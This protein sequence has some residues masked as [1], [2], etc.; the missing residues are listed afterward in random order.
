MAE[1]K[2][3]E[4]ST[5]IKKKKWY[6]I[7][8][9]KIFRNVVLGETYLTE[10]NLALN[11]TITQNLMNLTYDVKRQNSNIKFLIDKVEGDKAYTKIIG[12]HMI[13][14]SVRRLTRR[15]SEKIEQSLVCS[16]SDNKRVR[17]KPLIF[18]RRLIKGSISAK[19]AKTIIEYL[20]KTISKVTYD[21]LI[22]DLITHKLQNS[23]RERLKSIYPL[24]AVEIKSMEIEKEKKPMEE[25][26]TEKAEEMSETQ[27]VSEHAQKSKISDKPVEEKEKIKKEEK[28]EKKE[29]PKK[30]V[31]EEKAKEEIKQEE[32]KKEVKKETPKK[33]GKQEKSKEVNEEKQ[34]KEEK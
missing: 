19:L 32:P 33:E 8:A 26:K 30:E 12:Y 5:K 20:T 16:T 18:A 14:T 1:Q 13:P 23:L 31:K 17:I 22:N 21:N 7:I 2:K 34:S 10:P 4:K 3:T 29:E 24:R 11:K 9:P 28:V 25:K 15:R 27:S 6:S